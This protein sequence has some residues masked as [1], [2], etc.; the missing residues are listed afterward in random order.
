MARELEAGEAGHLEVGEDG[1]GECRG[2]LLEVPDRG[3]TGVGCLDVVAL[4]GHL[5]SEDF[6]GELVV[7]D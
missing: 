6:A 4:G 7:I 1:V 3:L 5:E 2:G